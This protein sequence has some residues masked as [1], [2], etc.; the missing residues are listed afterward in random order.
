MTSKSWLGYA[1]VTTLLWGVW[2]AFVDFP[3]Q[4]GFPETLSYVVWAL[5]M[6]AP[7][8]W[9]L[10]SVG[11]KVAHNR[12]A[13]VLGL[14]IGIL[15]AGGQLLVFRALAMGPAYLI[16][17]IISVSPA[18]TIV[19]SMLLLSERTGKLGIL[20]IVFALCALPLFDYAPDGQGHSYGGWFVLALLVLAAWGLQAYF[21]KLAHASLNAE[22]I[23]FYMT[24]SGLLLVPVA[25]YMTDFSQPI[26]VGWNGPWAA[27][28]IQVLNSIG[29]LTLV[30]AF[31]QGKAI[32]VSPL[33]NAGAP[34]LTTLLAILIA[35]AIPG[36]TK[37]A[38]M[39]LALLAALF[40]A[41]QP[42]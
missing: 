8:L 11:W 19:L 13:V 31:R 22:S 40:L 3:T 1:L 34:L 29:A 15:G 39:V 35:S 30:Y 6:T 36:P 27:A 20:G 18:L 7:A 33:T 28:A 9:A 2:G 5:T 24:L 12:R 16:F 38:A 14:A 10:R 41:A 4:H 23:F 25:L 21:I 37:I 42:D 26:N 32:I 17:P